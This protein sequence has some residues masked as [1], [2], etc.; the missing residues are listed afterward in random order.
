[1]SEAES[2]QYSSRAMSPRVLSPRALT[3]AKQ[4]QNRFNKLAP[5]FAWGATAFG[6]PFVRNLLTT[7]LMTGVA[8][9]GADKFRKANNKRVET[10]KA[11][12][13]YGVPKGKASN[14]YYNQN[15]A[16]H[17]PANSS[18]SAECFEDD[19]YCPTP[20]PEPTPTPSITNPMNNTPIN[21]VNK[22]A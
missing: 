13:V 5:A 18:V 11:Y 19:R 21:V 22:N 6:N 3:P 15:Y 2:S 4:K 12:G 9:Y 8:T 16:R 14:R 10:V 20:T 1:M 17:N 7:A